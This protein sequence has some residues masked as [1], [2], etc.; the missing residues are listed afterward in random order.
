MKAEVDEEKRQ[1][2]WFQNELRKAQVSGGLLTIQ[3]RLQLM[4]P[5]FVPQQPLYVAASFPQSLPTDQPRGM[6]AGQP[7]P[8]RVPLPMCTSCSMP[9]FHLTPQPQAGDATVQ[10]GTDPRSSPVVRIYSSQ[11]EKLG[12]QTSYDDHHI[13]NPILRTG[14]EE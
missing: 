10:M 14:T 12:K 6:M 9:H 1:H 11:T 8:I 7:V 2:L 3:L 5:P 4:A 13:A